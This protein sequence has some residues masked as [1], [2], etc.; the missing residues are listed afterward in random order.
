MNNHY[1][2]EDLATDYDLW[3]K[4]V[5]PQGTVSE[6]E[7]NTMSVDALKKIIIQFLWTKKHSF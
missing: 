6:E 7:F 5:D 1:T 4:Y 2:V 3:Q